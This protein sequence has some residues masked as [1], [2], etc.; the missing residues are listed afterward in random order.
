MSQKACHIRTYDPAASVIFCKT[1]E[2]FGGLSNMAAGFP[3]RVRDVD[4]RTSEALYQACRFPH[5]PDVQHKI[6]DERSPMTAKMKSKP[7]RKDSRRDWDEVRVK[8]MR[9]C[10]SVKLAQN[11]GE[12]GK[13]LLST[14]N[15]PIVELSR[16]DDYWGA[17]A[18]E[19]G[20]LVG[21][22]VL[23]RLLMQQREQLRDNK[24]DGL[25]RIEPPAI[26]E[27]LL[28]HEPIDAIFIDDNALPV[29]ET[30]ARASYSENNEAPLPLFNQ[31]R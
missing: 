15:N 21:K 1:K 29:V 7:F 28:F 3:L 19:D 23:G 27:F 31:S 9:W 20:V 11:W 25:H 22:N 2:N 18:T 8:I 13:L 30:K 16:K 17:K 6:I 10:L 5:M 26:P 24:L 14:G 12:F 4:I